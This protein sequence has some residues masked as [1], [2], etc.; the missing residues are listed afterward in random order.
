MNIVFLEKKGRDHGMEEG[1]KKNV[2]CLRK[3]NLSEP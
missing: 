2:T 3:N 1:K